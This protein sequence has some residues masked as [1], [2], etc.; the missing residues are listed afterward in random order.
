MSEQI[1]CRHFLQHMLRAAYR[2]HEGV[3]HITPHFPSASMA[4]DADDDGSRP[5]GL[6]PQAMRD[7]ISRK[8]IARYL[9][10]S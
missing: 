6:G 7:D 5:K 1:N 10:I 3:R 8:L 4:T 2:Y 9:V